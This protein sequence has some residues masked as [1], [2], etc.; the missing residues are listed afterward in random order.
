M[1]SNRFAL[2]EPTRL[3]VEAA[4]GLAPSLRER[5]PDA[6]RRRMVPADTIAEMRA[7]G[8]FRVMQPADR[9]GDGG[10]FA[11]YIVVAE[12]LGAGCP[13]TAW[14]YANVVLKSWMVGMYPREAQED[15][16]GKDDY[17]Y[18]RSLDVFISRLRKYLADDPQLTIENVHSVGFKLNTGDA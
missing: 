1:F 7:S 16:W 15:I 10:D 5:A 12:E 8:L 13:S 3:L 6:E 18:G 9:H 17:F 11:D 14:I 4:R 2:S